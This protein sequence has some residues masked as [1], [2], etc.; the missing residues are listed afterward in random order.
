MKYLKFQHPT[1]ILA[2]LCSALIIMPSC[3]KDDEPDPGPQ[4]PGNVY[5]ADL[6]NPTSEQ[7]QT[8]LTKDMKLLMGMLSSIKWMGWLI[9]KN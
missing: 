8:F 4:F 1:F 2:F 6:I 7:L 3:S 9:Y 5:E